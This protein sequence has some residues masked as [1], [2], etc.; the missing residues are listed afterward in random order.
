MAG[1][2]H[3]VTNYISVDLEC[4]SPP[5]V[6]GAE[7]EILPDDDKVI[8]TCLEGY[9]LIHP[10]VSNKDIVGQLRCIQGLW[11]PFTPPLCIKSSRLLL[12]GG[13]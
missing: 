11:T 9:D 4:P 3:F 2:I 8:Y 10:D 7:V 6:L 5:V 12:M 13:I 1:L